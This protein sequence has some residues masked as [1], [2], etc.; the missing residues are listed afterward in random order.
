MSFQTRARFLFFTTQLVL[1]ALPSAVALGQCLTTVT[2]L[3]GFAIECSGG[4]QIQ[5]IC[6]TYNKTYYWW[7]GPDYSSFEL[8]A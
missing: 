5:Y 7:L 6:E 8:L 4:G 3:R 2:T 1:L